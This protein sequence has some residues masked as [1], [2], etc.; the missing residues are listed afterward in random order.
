MD[1]QLEYWMNKW[2]KRL[3][4]KQKVTDKLIKQTAVS[5]RQTAETINSNGQMV[6]TV[7]KAYEKDGRISSSYLIVGQTNMDERMKWLEKRNT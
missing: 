5:S 7:C 4:G 1:K 2:V 3:N 6:E